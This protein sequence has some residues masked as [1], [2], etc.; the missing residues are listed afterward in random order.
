MLASLTFLVQGSTSSSGSSSSVGFIFPLILMVGV[1]YFL[2]IRPQQRRSRAQRSLMSE[3]D[4]GDEVITIGGV[5]GTVTGLD[6]E[7]VTIEVDRDVHIEFLR[8]AVA[9]RM[10]YDDDD[11]ADEADDEQDGAEDADDE[12]H[13]DDENH[14]DHEDSDHKGPWFDRDRTAKQEEAD[15]KK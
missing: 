1:F 2:L 11:V 14:E 9:R 5:H 15:E 13:E 7:Y 12:D 4:V 6:D 8:T 10:V 3:L